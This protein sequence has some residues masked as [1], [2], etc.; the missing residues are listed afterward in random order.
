MTLGMS[1]HETGEEGSSKREAF[2]RDV[3]NDLAKASGLP[4]ENFKITKLSAGSVIVDIDILPDPLGIAPAPSNVA[5]DLQKQA[6]DPNSP[7]R[8]GKL[9]SQTDGIQVLSDKNGKLFGEEFSCEIFGLLD[10]DGDGQLSREE[11]EAGFDL[12]D[13]D[14]DGKITKYEFMAATRTLYG[15]E[16]MSGFLFQVLDDDGDGFITKK[17][18]VDGFDY[19]DT[20]Q[21]GHITAKEFNAVAHLGLIFDAIDRD[22]DGFITREEYSAGFDTMDLHKN[23]KLCREEFSCECFDILDKDGDGQLSREEYEAGF[24]LFDIDGDGHI[25]KYEFGREHYYRMTQKVEEKPNMKAHIE[26]TVV[27]EWGEEGEGAIATF[28]IAPPEPMQQLKPN[29]LPQMI[30]VLPAPMMSMPSSA[31]VATLIGG[32]LFKKKI[33]VEIE[34]MRQ[35]VA[36]TA[37]SDVGIFVSVST[38]SA[39]Q[40]ARLQTLPAGVVLAADDS[41]SETGKSEDSKFGSAA[42]FLG[43]SVPMTECPGQFHALRQNTISPRPDRRPHASDQTAFSNAGLANIISAPTRPSNAD[44]TAAYQTGPGLERRTLRS[45]LESI[46]EQAAVISNT[47]RD[48]LQPSALPQPRSGAID[49]FKA[50]LFSSFT[51]APSARSPVYNSQRSVPDRQDYAPTSAPGS[52]Y[53]AQSLQAQDNVSV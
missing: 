46:G 29:P 13:V 12:F 14:K 7:L 36:V 31:P 10:T 3:A 33:A 50:N 1:F 15:T 23:G 42:A 44:S 26:R 19:F 37:T 4:A 51:P 25:T 18:W 41:K 5:R 34:E 28:K 16:A 24:D 2:K 17:E 11:Y 48:G 22:G 9:T 52:A 21:D 40:K 47:I 30:S 20:D 39:S 43:E 32:P 38:P 6:A 45:D 35:K 53:Q 27:V 8:S 49:D